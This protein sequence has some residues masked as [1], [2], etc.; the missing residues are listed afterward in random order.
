MSASKTATSVAVLGAGGTMGLP[1]AR[2]IARA[3]MDVRAWNRTRE[4]AEPLADDGAQ[5]FDSPAEAADGADVIL[6]MLADADAVIDSMGGDDGALAR[7]GGSAVWLQMSTIGEAG[8]E[9][10]V[11]LAN[12]HEVD[13][14][15]SPVLGT[16][17]PAEQGKLV[18]MASGADKLRDRVQPILDAV[19]QRTMWIG[20]E[21]GLAS[22]LKVVTNNWILTV[23][24]GTAE[25][26]ALAEASGLDPAL[27]LEAVG[28]GPLDLPYLQMKGKAIA[29][30]SF[31]PS[32]SL[33]LAPRTPAWSRRQPNGMASTFRCRGP[34]GSEWQRGSTS[35]ATRT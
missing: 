29:E 8:T 10:C 31:E 28:G 22:R 19:G 26:I 27:F 30:R 9:R 32:F 24:E 5:I 21:P 23:V 3:G 13:F 17:D 1:M 35:T 2:N 20:E 16:K 6:T 25:T 4:K 33:K 14:V 12:E 18:A 15:D 7:A 11:Q 34:S